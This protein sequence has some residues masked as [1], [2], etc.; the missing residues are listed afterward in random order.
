VKVLIVIASSLYVL[1][2]GEGFVRTFA[3]AAIMPRFVTPTAYG[4]RGNVPS[5]SY[6]HYT[7]EVSVEY[8]INSAGIRAD[9]E[10]PLAKPADTCRVVLFGDSF[11]MGYEVDLKDAFATLLE[12]NLHEAGY[13][14]EVVNLAVSGYGTAEMLIELENVGLEYSPD[15]IIFQ[16]HRTDPEDNVRSDLFRVTSDGRLVRHAQTYLPSMKLRAMLDHVPLYRWLEQNSQL[17]CALRERGAVITKRQIMVRRRQEAQSALAQPANNQKP[18]GPAPFPYRLR[19]TRDLLVEGNR[20][21]HE[22]GAQFMVFEVPNALSRTEFDTVD[23]RLT[24]NLP[25]DVAYTTPIEA[26]RKHARPNIKL[27]YEHGAGHWT[28]LGNQI[29]AR[30]AAQALIAKG[31]LDRWR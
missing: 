2:V 17:F 31:W 10:I 16:W 25:S 14:C 20:V 19:L 27:Y 28:P 3:P 30:E 5:I 13:H 11:F 22:H 4:L 21:A 6:W 1:L 9:R 26:F 18:A 23:D 15:V 24:E 12:K 29:A 7:P 8:R